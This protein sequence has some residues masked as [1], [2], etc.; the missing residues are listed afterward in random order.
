MVD[1]VPEQRSP[2]NFNKFEVFIYDDG[3]Y[4]MVSV[5]GKG[6]GEMHV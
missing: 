2:D 4:V 5:I 6:S 1:F 3:I